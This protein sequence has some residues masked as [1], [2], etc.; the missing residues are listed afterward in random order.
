MENQAQLIALFNKYL[1]NECSL[2][3]VKELMQ[4]FNSDQRELLEEMV[5]SEFE[6][7][8]LEEVDLPALP[9]R[10]FDGI[11]FRIE[12]V[13]TR[14][15]WPRI[16]IVAA[17]SIAFAVMVGGYFYYNSS[18]I[19]DH[20]EIVYQNDIA[21]GKEGATLTL[22]NGQKILINNTL[23]GN[24]ATQAGVK[25]SKTANGEIIYEVTADENK[26]LTYNTL[27][28]TRGEQTRVRLPDGTIVFLNSTS[29]LKY[30]TSF[31]KERKVELTGEAYF[32]VAHNKAKP[33]KVMSKG[34][35]V[36]VLGTHFN[37]NN[38]TDEV[39]TRTTLLEGSVRLN[40][41]T[42]LKPGEQAILSKTG[43]ILVEQVAVDDVI[44][45]TNGKFIFDS[46]SIESIMRKL[47]RWY[48]IEVV[49]E[50]EVKD[51]QFAG[52][53]SR[54]DSISK[55]LDKITFTQAAHFKIEGRRVT[56]IP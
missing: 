9:K 26:N 34:Q 50:G 13:K 23:A 28:T 3:E 25:I 38:Y 24:I 14:K 47:S 36:E 37:I 56:V 40:G 15:L 20:K 27:T 46:E 19:N 7:L 1:L 8:T 33:F 22:A 30:P 32:E 4:Y 51:K 48:N 11:K 44:A 18:N 29:V 35:E 39:D 12:A 2:E 6:K 16:R 49:Y 5:T 55:I 52:S 41:N 31:G 54:K 53:I 45:W 10:V 43:K 42:I 21:P 17:A